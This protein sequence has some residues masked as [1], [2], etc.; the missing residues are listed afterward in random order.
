MLMLAASARSEGSSVLHQLTQVLDHTEHKTDTIYLFIYFF[1]SP[2]FWWYRYDSDS[3][4]HLLWQNILLSFKLLYV[5]SGFWPR[6]RA[7]VLLGSKTCPTGRLAPPRPSQLCCFLFTPPKLS[8][9]L[10]LGPPGAFTVSF[11]WAKLHPTELH[12]IFLSYAAPSWAPLHPNEL[13]CTLLRYAV[14]SKLWYI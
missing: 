12:C 5:T 10:E 4:I 11:H 6:M 1:F 7:H 2:T 3:A 13:Q 8:L 14:P 9:R